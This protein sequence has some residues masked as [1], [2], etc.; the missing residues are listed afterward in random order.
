MK[1]N[2]PAFLRS[3]RS[4]LLLFSVSVCAVLAWVFL[5]A[6]ATETIDLGYVPY[7]YITT[8]PTS[9]ETRQ[10]PVIKAL[11]NWLFNKPSVKRVKISWKPSP[12]SS[13][14]CYLTYDR[15]TQKLYH[16]FDEAPRGRYFWHTNWRFPFLHRGQIFG[17]NCPYK[18]EMT[19]PQKMLK[20]ALTT[21]SWQF[22]NSR[23]RALYEQIYVIFRIVSA[24]RQIGCA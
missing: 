23:E 9:E 2:S 4:K 15:V 18:R 1:N 14:Q 12:L 3:R 21:S 16:Q 10:T 11:R 5:R 13:F 22:P 17:G 20:I 8:F 19:V 6:N 24:G 7:T